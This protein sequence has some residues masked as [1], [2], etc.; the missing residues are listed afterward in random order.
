ME[1]ENFLKKNFRH[2]FML[3]TLV[4]VAGMLFSLLAIGGAGGTVMTFLF[5]AIECLIA[6]VAGLG[7]K[8][9]EGNNSAG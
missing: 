5:L 3:G 7:L 9:L 4:C 1:K 8:L 6:G 2:F